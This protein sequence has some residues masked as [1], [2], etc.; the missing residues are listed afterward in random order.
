M[1]E[2]DGKLAVDLSPQSADMSFNDVGFWIEVKLPDVLEKHRTSHDTPG[3]P[4]QVF[5]QLE[6]LWLQIDRLTGSNHLSL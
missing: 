6:F 2:S 4:H 1:N 5:E 3:I